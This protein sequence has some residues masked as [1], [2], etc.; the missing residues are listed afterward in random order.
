MN[1]KKLLNDHKEEVIMNLKNAFDIVMKYDG[2]NVTVIWTLRDII[3]YF[4][5]IKNETEDVIKLECFRCGNIHGFKYLGDGNIQH[6][7]LPDTNVVSCDGSEG[8]INI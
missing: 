7:K 6:V 8:D 1:N 4:E 3:E 2:D 5:V